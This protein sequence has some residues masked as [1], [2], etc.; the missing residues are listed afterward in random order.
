MGAAAGGGWSVAEHS[1]WE[2]VGES[3]PA[4]YP[5]VLVFQA[6]KPVLQ[7]FTLSIDAQNH[8]SCRKGVKGVARDTVTF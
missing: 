8:T 7:A 5:L 4:L 1:P 2:F 3:V 6:V